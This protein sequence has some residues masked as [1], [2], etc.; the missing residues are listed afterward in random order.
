MFF[1]GGVFELASSVFAILTVN[2]IGRKKLVIGCLL[3]ASVGL[4]CSVIVNES[5]NGDEGKRFKLCCKI[6]FI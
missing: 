1:I 6:V 4:T 2:R 5:A 3:V